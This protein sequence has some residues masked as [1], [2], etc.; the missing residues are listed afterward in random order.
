MSAV[1]SADVDTLQADIDV[2]ITVAAR[3]AFEVSFMCVLIALFLALSL[4]KTQERFLIFLT[5]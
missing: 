2:A 5:P 3:R 4:P 1:P